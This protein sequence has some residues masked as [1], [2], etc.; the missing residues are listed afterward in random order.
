LAQNKK[1]KNPVFTPM[2]LDEYKA[3]NEFEQAIGK[4]SVVFY[5]M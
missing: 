5:F 3:L 4:D 2:T 1:G